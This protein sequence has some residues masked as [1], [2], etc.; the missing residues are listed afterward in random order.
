MSNCPTAMLAANRAVTAPTVAT[1]SWAA[2]AAVYS[3]A[4]RAT[5]YTPAVT[6][7]AAWISADTGVG[8]AIA[9]GSQ[10]YSGICADLPVTPSSKN[11]VISTINGELTA[12]MLAAPW[13]TESNC[14][15]PKALNIKKAA[16]RKPKSPMRL[17]IMA[18]LAA[19]E[20][21]HDGRASVSISYQKP[22]N[23]K[24]HSPTPSQPTK[25]IKYESPATRI[26]ME[27]MKRFRNTK[28]RRK[29]PGSDL[30]RTS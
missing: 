30:K 24:E 17:A 27:A 18:F 12:E 2:G 25:S 21:A 13:N 8:P 19:S 3:G 15:L 29:R 14:R 16:I 5:R 10:T 6:I 23:R 9:S 26:I 4:E 7:V 22:I 28:K 1:T 11:R 20:L